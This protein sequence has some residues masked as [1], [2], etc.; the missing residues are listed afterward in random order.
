MVYDAI[1]PQ[2]ADLNKQ[3]TKLENFSAK[4]DSFFF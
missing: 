2:A 3:I 1:L 4:F